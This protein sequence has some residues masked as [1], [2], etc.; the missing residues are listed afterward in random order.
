MECLGDLIADRKLRE[1]VI[2]A[3]HDSGTFSLVGSVA[4]D[5]PEL[6]TIKQNLIGGW[7]LGTPIVTSLIKKWSVTQKFDIK[8]QLKEGIRFFDLRIAHRPPSSKSKDNEKDRFFIVHGLWG[9]ALSTLLDTMVNFIRKHT[10][11]ILILDFNHL[12][13]FD[14]KASHADLM[15]LIRTSFGDLLAP[16]SLGIDISVRDLWDKNQRVI[17]SYDAPECDL[18]TQLWPMSSTVQAPWANKASVEAVTSYM[19]NYLFRNPL[20]TRTSFANLQ[21]IITPDGDLI[22]RS[23]LD[24]EFGLKNIAINA[25]QR[26]IAWLLT[27][28][29]EF[30]RSANIISCDFVDTVPLVEIA[31]CFNTGSQPQHPHF[32]DHQVWSSAQYYDTIRLI[33]LPHDGEKILLFARGPKGLNVMRFDLEHHTKKG[34]YWP[35]V[36]SVEGA[37]HGD[38]WDC[39]QQYQTLSAFCASNRLFV[40]GRSFNGLET[41]GTRDLSSNWFCCHRYPGFYDRDGYYQPQFFR[42]LQTFVLNNEAV[43]LISRMPDN[44]FITLHFESTTGKWDLFDQTSTFFCSDTQWSH[45][46]FYSSIRSFVLSSDDGTQHAYIVARAPPSGTLITLRFNPMAQSGAKWT[47]PGNDTENP[48]LSDLEGWRYAPCFSTIRVFSCDDNRTAYLI[49]RSISGLVT[50]LF[51]NTKQAWRRVST[52]PILQDTYS[53][54]WAQ[55]HHYSTIRQLVVRNVGGGSDTVLL[56]A[57]GENA[58]LTFRLDRTSHEWYPFAAPLRS[59]FQDAHGWTAGSFYKS[60]VTFSTNGVAFVGFRFGNTLCTLRLIDEDGDPQW[61]CIR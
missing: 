8:Q 41:Y 18:P 1:L 43:Y 26:F 49:A 38:N 42:T 36:C 47:T 48:I 53:G 10:K 37:F 15:D 4:I 39:P 19:E 40:V 23:I 29:Q 22:K 34:D 13:G 31:K 12:Y 2:P 20:D 54:Q 21:L 24:G 44:T 5:T 61:R 17:V 7:V 46:A 56:V 33:S 52:S 35:I 16:R 50:Y 51:D 6:V 59:P 14:D 58:L 30:R 25:N 3:T 9:D 27:L 55:S 11:E 60:I 57:R 28:P 45:P 32:G